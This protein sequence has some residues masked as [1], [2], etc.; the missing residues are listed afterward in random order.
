M[1]NKTII[2]TFVG[3]NSLGYE[4]GKTYTINVSST[5]MHPIRIHR[6][7][8][9]GDCKYESIVAFLNNWNDIQTKEF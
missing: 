1:K 3:G 7:D 6:E 9:A 2:A 5:Q 4:N 8:S